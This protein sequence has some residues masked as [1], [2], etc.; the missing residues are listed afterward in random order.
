MKNYEDLSS[1]ILQGLEEK[2]RPFIEFQNQNKLH[3]P[4]NCG[5]CCFNREVHCHPF[6]LL[7]LAI[8]LLK[9]NK[10]EEILENAKNYQGKYCFFLEVTDEEKGNG[11]CR[12]YLNRPSL[13]RAFGVAGRID[14]NQKIELSTCKKLQETYQFI[15]NDDTK[16]PLIN[17]LKG[18]I[19]QIDESLI[20]PTYSIHEALIIILE[21]VLLWNQYKS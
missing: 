21:K 12:V 9:E 5:K 18:N 13:C 8:K 7:P 17:Y 4:S 6:E 20:G 14:K 10:I 19:E 3:C 11:F 2:T 1:I 15:L 16:I